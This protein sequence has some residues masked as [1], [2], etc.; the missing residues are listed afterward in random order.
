MFTSILICGHCVRILISC[1]V[2]GVDRGATPV[3]FE[4][5]TD[6]LL[7]MSRD[8]SKEQYLKAT[9][10]YSTMPCHASATLLGVAQ[11][12]ACVIS[13]ASTAD[14]SAAARLTRAQ[15]LL[16]KTFSS[17]RFRACVGT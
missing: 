15:L 16:Y 7:C 6:V 9:G 4:L 2:A 8:L 17:F 10:T 5:Y 13:A 12:D 1:T 3:R 14:S 11:P